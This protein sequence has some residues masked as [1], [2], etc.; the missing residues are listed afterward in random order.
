MGNS[1]WLEGLNP[2]E[3]FFVIDGDPDEATFLTFEDIMPNDFESLIFKPSLALG[4]TIV[5][6][7]VLWGVLSI[8]ILG[9]HDVMATRFG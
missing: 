3:G 9:G 5:G 6:Q 2:P 7:K 1:N 4:T 8:G